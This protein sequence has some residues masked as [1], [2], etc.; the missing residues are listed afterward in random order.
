MTLDWE[1]PSST[2]ATYKLFFRRTCRS[3]V[4]SVLAKSE[5]ELKKN[6]NLSRDAL[7]GFKMHTYTLLKTMR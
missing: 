6:K 2:P 5:I 7:K 3:K 4:G 1:V